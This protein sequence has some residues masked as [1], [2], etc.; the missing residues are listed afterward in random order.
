MLGNDK[1]ATKYHLPR[2]D[3]HHSLHENGA[4]AGIAFDLSKKTTDNDTDNKEIITKVIS[5]LLFTT[6]CH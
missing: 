2:M 3:Y 6:S 5:L 1:K 4:V